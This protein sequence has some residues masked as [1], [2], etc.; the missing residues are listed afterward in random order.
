M[1][2]R[3]LFVCV[4]CASVRFIIRVDCCVCVTEKNT[5]PYTRARTLS[6]CSTTP[7][8]VIS[9]TI[10]G[11]RSTSI[12]PACVYTAVQQY[13]TR[14]AVP[15]IYGRGIRPVSTSKFRKVHTVQQYSSV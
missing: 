11:M 14:Q 10:Y 2:L 9:S 12:Y 8:F 1:F 6:V 5:F 13:H 3:V 15:G 7:V 4:C